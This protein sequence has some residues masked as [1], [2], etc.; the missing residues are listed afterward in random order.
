MFLILYYYL[1]AILVRLRRHVKTKHVLPNQ[2]PTFLP[3]NMTTNLRLPQFQ[4]LKL[5]KGGSI[6]AYMFKGEGIWVLT[7]PPEIFLSCQLN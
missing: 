6:A 4:Y 1:A 2:R 3:D 5:T 7:T